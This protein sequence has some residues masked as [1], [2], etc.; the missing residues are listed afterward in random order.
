MALVPVDESVIAAAAVVDREGPL[1]LPLLLLLLLH[2]KELLSGF[3]LLF[4][5]FLVVSCVSGCGFTGGSFI[6]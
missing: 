5:A 3:G 4:I 1:Q 6:F 2:D